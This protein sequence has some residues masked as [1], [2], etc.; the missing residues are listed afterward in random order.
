VPRCKACEQEPKKEQ[1]QDKNKTKTRQ[2]Q[3][4]TNNNSNKNLR[5]QI[6]PKV[7]EHPLFFSTLGCFCRDTRREKP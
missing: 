6:K 5:N 4:K 2:K 3:N 1:K 7:K